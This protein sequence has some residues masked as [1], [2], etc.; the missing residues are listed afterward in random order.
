MSTKYYHVEAGVPRDPEERMKWYAQ[1]FVIP[2]PQDYRDLARYRRAKSNCPCK[3]TCNKSGVSAWNENS[4]CYVDS[5]CKTGQN[6]AWN[7]IP[8][9]SGLGLGFGNSKWKYCN[10]D[11]KIGGAAPRRSKMRKSRNPAPNKQIRPVWNTQ[12]T[13]LPQ[14]AVFHPR[15]AGRMLPPRPVYIQQNRSIYFPRY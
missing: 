10:P 11:Q 9:L 2:S 1:Q 14:V 5:D 8:G 13:T 12:Q 6:S 7:W 15:V 4:Y 3:T